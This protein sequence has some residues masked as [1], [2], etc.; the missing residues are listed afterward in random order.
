MGSATYKN[1]GHKWQH[2]YTVYILYTGA[3]PEFW[4]GGHQKTFH[5]WIPFKSCTA[6]ASPKFRLG[7]NI[8]HKSTHQ[9]LL[10]NFEKFYKKFA[11]KFKISPKF[12]KNKI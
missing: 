4:L 8:Q 11:Q 12:F 2:K 9:R 10:K 7:E 3:A 5:T 1:G 6:M